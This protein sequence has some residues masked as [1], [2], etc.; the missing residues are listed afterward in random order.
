MQRSRIGLLLTFSLIACTGENIDFGKDGTGTEGAD[1]SM[2]PA[3]PDSDKDGYTT[4][5]GDCDDNDPAVHPGATEICGDNR[6]N[7]CD[8]KADEGCG[9][10]GSY[11]SGT[12]SDNNPGT[13]AQPVATIGKGIA[14]ALKIGNGQAVYVAAG[15]YPEKIKLVEGV[16]LLGGHQC[17]LSFCT[18]ARDPR[19][20]DGQYD[21]A[22]LSPDAEGVLADKTITRRTHLDGFRIMGRAGT[23]TTAA[24][25]LDGG[26]PTI[27]NNRIYGGNITSGTGVSTSAVRIYASS[28]QQGALIAGNEIHGGTSTDATMGILIQGRSGG[29]A[30]PVTVVISKNVI[31]GG[32][33]RSASGITAW[34]SAAAT[35]IQGNDISSGSASTDGGSA[36]GIVSGSSMTID[37]NHINADPAQVGTCTSASIFCGGI[38]SVSSSAVITNNVVLGLSSPRS[39][40]IYLQEAE[41]AGG[42]VVFNGNYADGAGI[43][44]GDGAVSA[45]MVTHIGTC[46]TCGFRGVMGKTRNNILSGGKSRNRFGVLE[47]AVA[48]R[49]NRPE[50]LENNLFYFPPAAAA[51]NDVIY[52]SWDGSKSTDLTTIAAVNQLTKPAAAKNLS[53]DPMVDGSYHLKAGS[54]CIDKGTATEAPTADMDGEAR[55]RGAAIDIGPDEAM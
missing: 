14:N 46:M 16:D 10:L 23:A 26:T 41:I 38:N 27:T 28:D 37:A 55:P 47:D 24:F 39:A 15:H 53:G 49:T 33:G 4:C 20:T 51:R 30:A 18:W 17:S 45:A 12:G 42:M 54:P 21:T 29:A 35:L 13:Q 9:G 5:A 44:M 43:A 2:G 7:T 25:S 32:T 6:D 31:L 11:V 36:W 1:M 34:S 3:C 50:A 8:G 22:L 52:R 19:S 48:G 40:A